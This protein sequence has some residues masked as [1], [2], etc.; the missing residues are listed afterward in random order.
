MNI[1]SLRVR[2][3]PVE[4]NPMGEA[5][6]WYVRH[7]PEAICVRCFVSGGSA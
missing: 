7:N 3:Q 6:I 5:G 2:N 1:S 4:T